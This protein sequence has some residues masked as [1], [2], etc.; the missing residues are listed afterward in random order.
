ML[1]HQRKDGSNAKVNV[2][3]R[4]RTR[5]K[6]TVLTTDFAL[7]SCCGLAAMADM[8]LVITLPLILILY[9]ALSTNAAVNGELCPTDVLFRRKLRYDVSMSVVECWVL[10][11]I[12]LN[13][14]MSFKPGFI[15][16]CNPATARSESTKLSVDPKGE[17][18]V[19]TNGRAVIVSPLVPV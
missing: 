4:S 6:N 13:Q 8:L 18:L 15:L 10:T 11:P 16:P 2:P 12:L 1:D 3:R 9:V 5:A 7:A 17:K 19:Y 14:A